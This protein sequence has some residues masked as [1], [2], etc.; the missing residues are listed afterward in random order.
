M[1]FFLVGEPGIREN[2]I[3][4]APWGLAIHLTDLKGVFCMRF[5][6]QQVDV[7]GGNSGFVSLVWKLTA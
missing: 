1:G 5:S 3:I 4:F 2:G 6:A 7:V